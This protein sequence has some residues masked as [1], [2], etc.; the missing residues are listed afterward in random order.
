MTKQSYT[1][2]ARYECKI[3]DI[4]NTKKIRGNDF[5]I[6]VAYSE[7]AYDLKIEYPEESTIIIK[8]TRTSPT[9]IEVQ[10]DP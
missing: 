4:R 8:L 1:E 2:I 5:S 9:Q 6:T 7:L 3:N 10:E